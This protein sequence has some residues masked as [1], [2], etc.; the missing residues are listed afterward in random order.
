MEGRQTR[1]FRGLRHRAEDVGNPV[2]FRLQLIEDVL[3]CRRYL[4]IADGFNYGHGNLLLHRRRGGE[5]IL[6]EESVFS[7]DDAY[8]L[9]SRMCCQMSGGDQQYPR[10]TFLAGLLFPV[11]RG[12]DE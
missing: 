12:Q 4:L 6:S 9:K 11:G 10:S 3:R 5:Q 8:D 2:Q 7:T 1:T